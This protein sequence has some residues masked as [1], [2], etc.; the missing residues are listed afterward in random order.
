MM[1][2]VPANPSGMWRRRGIGQKYRSPAPQSSY[3]AVQTV[4]LV[5]TG[6]AVVAGG[7]AVVTMGPTGLG[8]KWY[9]STASFS[10]STG[11]SDGSQVVMYAGFISQSQLIDA[12]V[13]DGGGDT[14]GLAIPVMVPGETIIAVWNGA[15]NGDIAQMTIAGTMDGL[16]PG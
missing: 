7:T 14:A 9:P 11:P 16:V 1:L 10:T 4:P 13:Y 2:P 6:Q 5:R 3:T 12:R 15:H 8:F